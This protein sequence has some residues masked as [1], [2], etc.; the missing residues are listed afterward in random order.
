MGN[1]ETLAEVR[2][3]TPKVPNFLRLPDFDNATISISKLSDE[4]LRE[5]GEKWTDNLI[6]RA[7]EIRQQGESHTMNKTALEELVAACEEEFGVTGNCT[8]EP[9]DESVM[10]GV[11]ADGTPN[12]S[13]ITF[14]M[15]RRARAALDALDD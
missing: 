14:G 13:P 12:D 11:N 3:A 2:V 6:A 7:E 10:S 8:D 9:D 5:I 1:E 15:I 4:T